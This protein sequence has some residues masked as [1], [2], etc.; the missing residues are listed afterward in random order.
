MKSG[1]QGVSESKLRIARDCIVDQAERFR[2][3]VMGIAAASPLKQTTGAQIQFIGGDIARRV[4]LHA[5][6]LPWRQIRAQGLRDSFR[7][8]ALQ[9]E[10]IG[11]FTVERLRPEMRVG[12]GVDELRVDSDAIAHAPRRSLQN[13]CNTQ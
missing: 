12:A 3:L 6:L 4:S 7:Q 1:T 5:R 13:M 2:A 9:S 8:F 11:D 10:K